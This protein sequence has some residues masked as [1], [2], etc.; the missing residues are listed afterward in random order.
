MVCFSHEGDDCVCC[1]HSELR[2]ESVFAEPVIFRSAWLPSCGVCN[3]F[4]PLR[5]PDFASSFVVL[6][7]LLRYAHSDHSSNRS[8]K[9]YL[10]FVNAISL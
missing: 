8:R 9:L 5:T 4:F 2:S 1:G 7:H 10:F 6:P 3:H